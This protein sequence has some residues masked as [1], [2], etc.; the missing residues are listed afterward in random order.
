MPARCGSCTRAAAGLGFAGSAVFQIV[1][2][3][4]GHQRPLGRGAPVRAELLAAGAEH[5]G[6]PGG[7]VLPGLLTAVH[8]HVEQR[9]GGCQH[10]RG[11]GLETRL[12]SQ[13]A[14]IWEELGGGGS[15]GVSGGG[16]GGE[17]W[18][19]RRGEG[20]GR[21]GGG[22]GGHMWKYTI[23]WRR[24]SK[25]SASR[26][27][28]RSPISGIAGSISTIGSRRR[29]AAI[30]S[31]SLVCAFSRTRR[32]SS[33]ACH[34]ARSTTAG[35]VAVAVPVGVAVPRPARNAGSAARCSPA[36]RFLAHPS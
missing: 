24:P 35:C 14:E 19:R 6:P 7:R 31:P 10:L 36:P 4:G 11:R 33:C 29:A 26:T 15:V 27:G 20:G 21:E 12:A 3:P 17:V 9:V 30:A 8:R 22:A 13:R 5:S 18:R 16:G 2:A 25:T 34:V 28:P 32:S 1:R 23:S